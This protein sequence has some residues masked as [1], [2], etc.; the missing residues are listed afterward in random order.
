MLALCEAQTTSDPNSVV[1]RGVNIQPPAWGQHGLPWWLR[2]QR[3]CLSY[4]RSEFDSWVRKIPWRREW[5]STLVFLPGEFH[6]Q[7][8]LAGYGPWGHKESEMTAYLTPSLFTGVRGLLGLAGSPSQG[9]PGE[10]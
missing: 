3:V 8:S 2:W 7:R 6:G 5:Q 4:R 10:S 1:G 9:H